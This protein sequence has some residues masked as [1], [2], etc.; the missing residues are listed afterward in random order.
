MDCVAI[1]RQLIDMANS[2][3][4]GTLHCVFVDLRKAFDTVHRRGLWITLERQGVPP[5]LLAVARALHDGM[6][7]KV[8]VGGN[9]SGPFPVREGVR[10]GCLVAPA[11]LN[12]YYAAVLDEW[13]RELPADVEVRYAI[14][15]PDSHVAGNGGQALREAGIE[16]SEG[17]GAEEASYQLAGYL[18]HRRTGLPLV[19]VK[20]AAS[21]DGRI[22]ASSGDSRWVSGSETLAWAHEQR[23]ALDAIVVGSNTVVIDDPQ[24][25]ARPGGSSEGAHQ[26]L[27]IVLDSR[28]RTPADCAR[29]GGH[30]DLARA[31]D[32]LSPVFPG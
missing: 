10:Q 28:G 9:L 23:P 4:S 22:A 21:L 32:A 1:A 25:T 19:V 15:D 24:L 26:P 18:K 5:R 8:R 3:D 7:A 14:E 12:L 11:L 17:D 31:L 16:A 30:D 13:R 6:H 29:L 20:F 27:R 2:S